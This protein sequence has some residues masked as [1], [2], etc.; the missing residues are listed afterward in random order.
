MKSFSKNQIIFGIAGIA[1]SIFGFMISDEN[2]YPT[3]SKLSIP[4]IVI[5][6]I[7]VGFSLAPSWNPIKGLV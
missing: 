5:G 1:L 6:L 3:L 2:N 7:V 4:V